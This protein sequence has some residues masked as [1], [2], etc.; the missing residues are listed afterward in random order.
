MAAEP[1]LSSGGGR[2]EDREA[3]CERRH[4]PFAGVKQRDAEPDRGMQLVD[5]LSARHSWRRQWIEP[6]SI[7]GID[8]D[9]IRHGAQVGLVTGD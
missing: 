6:F 8:T 1:N 7:I 9:P 4:T 5:H 2:F 3:S